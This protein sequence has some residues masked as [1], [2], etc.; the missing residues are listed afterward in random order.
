MGRTPR[1]S[2]VDA[3]K[4]KKVLLKMAAKHLKWPLHGNVEHMV[5]FYNKLTVDCVET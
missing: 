1:V 4:K 5:A 3:K 2:I